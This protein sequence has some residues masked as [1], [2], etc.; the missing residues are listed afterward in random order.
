[1]GKFPE[2]TTDQVHIEQTVMIQKAKFPSAERWKMKKFLVFTA[3]KAKMPSAGRP[4]LASK[5][6]YGR[7]ITVTSV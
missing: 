5:Q 6:T 3:K 7:I 4:V 2:P 1:L